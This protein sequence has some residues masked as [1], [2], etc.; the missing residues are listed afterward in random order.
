[1]PEANVASL[2]KR[3]AKRASPVMNVTPLVDVVLVLLIIFM[4]V[5]PAMDAGA[6]VELPTVVNVEEDPEDEPLVVSIEG[7]GTLWLDEVV[8]GA[9]GLEVGLEAAHL[10]DSQRRVVI[11]ADEGARYADTRAV[12]AACRGAGFSR[13][14]LQVSEAPPT[15]EVGD[16]DDERPSR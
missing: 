13:I 1:L 14:S 4:V 8:V 7:G 12:F 2:G 15:G 5:I 16:A 3:G 6:E 11:K 10:D 9:A